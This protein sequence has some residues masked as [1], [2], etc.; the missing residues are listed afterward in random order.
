MPSVADIVAAVRNGEREAFNELV[1]RFQDMALGYACSLLD[2]YHEAE[3]AA[4]EAFVHAYIDLQALRDPAAFPGWFRSLVRTQCTRRQRRNR[5]EPQADGA[6]AAQIASLELGAQEMLEA[7]ER[8]SQVVEAIRSLPEHEQTTVRL[9]YMGRQSTREIADFL[10]VSVGAVKVRLHSARKRLREE[11][12]AMVQDEL[13]TQ[14][15]SRDADFVE[16]VELHLDAVQKLHEQFGVLLRGVLAESLGTEP[17]LRLASVSQCSFV[18]FLRLLSVPCAAYSMWMPP[19]E[20]LLLL[21]LPMSLACAIVDHA[22]DIPPDRSEGVRD[23]T[24]TEYGLLVPTLTRIVEEFEATWGTRFPVRVVDV[25]LETHPLAL[26]SDFPPAGLHP[27]ADEPVVHLAFEIVFGQETQSINLCY[28]SVS[29]AAVLPHIKAGSDRQPS[30]PL[31]SDM[32]S[33]RASEYPMNA[34]V[35]KDV[36]VM[37]CA[38]DEAYI[39][40]N[41]VPLYAHDT[42]M[43]L[44]HSVLLPNEHGVLDFGD[45]R[46]LSESRPH[47]CRSWW[48]R[49]EVLFPLLIRVDGRPAGFCVVE[50]PRHNPDGADH[51]LTAF[52]L[53]HPYRRGDVGR[54]ALRQVFDRFPGQWEISVHAENEYLRESCRWALT[55]RGVPVDWISS[56]TKFAFR[57]GE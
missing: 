57:S 20:G 19:L 33:R 49:P 42:A 15:A 48:K 53:F 52:F 54:C 43:H 18:E 5:R 6:E 13:S 10:D 7:E 46:E 1:R 2:D 44:V 39:I 12:M 8:R 31:P 32:P 51:Y 41:M 22:S 4:Q 29:L 40:Q 55:D 47:R 11:L 30:P 23:L 35:F 34:L 45:T 26:I 27:N 50:S 37:P 36:E 14:R 56:M 16:Q 38:E 17:T 28:P 24:N 21:D 9:F 25:E 3:D